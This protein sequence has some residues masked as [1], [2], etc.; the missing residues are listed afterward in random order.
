MAKILV[1]EDNPAN[2]DLITFLLGK[3]GHECITALDG[4]EGVEAARQQKPDL[5]LCDIQMPRVDGYGVVRILKDD[6][7]LKAIPVMAV[8]SYAMHGDKEKAL[9]RGFD[10]YITKPIDP[11][12]FV[13]DVEAVLGKR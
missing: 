13:D 10:G 11:R 8:S 7:E 4:I 6:A 12:T 2:L 3:F 5:I 1:I 9:A